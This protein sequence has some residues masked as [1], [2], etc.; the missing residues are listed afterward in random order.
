METI[1]AK[2]ALEIIEPIPAEQFCTGVFDNEMGQCC[3]IGHICKALTANTGGGYNGDAYADYDG[4]G[5]RGLSREFIKKHHNIPDSIASVNNNI[6]VNGY[7]EPVIKDRVVHL[8]K[9]MILA[10]Y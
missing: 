1:N 7:T 4:F 9:D 10:G 2:K 3:V 6:D 8:L 5:I